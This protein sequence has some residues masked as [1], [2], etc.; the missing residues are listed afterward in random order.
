MEIYSKG[1]KRKSYKLNE[2]KKKNSKD[3]QLTYQNL[4]YDIIRNYM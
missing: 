1:S 3:Y 4:Y 2:G